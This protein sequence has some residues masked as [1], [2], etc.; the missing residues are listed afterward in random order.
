MR[1]LVK[2]ILKSMIK[3]KGRLLMLIVSIAL[4]TGLF[5]G[6]QK[7]FETVMDSQKKIQMEAFEGKEV[8]ITKK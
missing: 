4:S 1:I 8:S 6:S 3:N 5:I 2:Y 7:A